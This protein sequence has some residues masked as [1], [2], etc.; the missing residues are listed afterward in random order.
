MPHRGWT[1]INVRDTNPDELP[2]DEAEYET[3]QACEKYPI[4]F[5]HTIV[6]DDWPDEVDVGRICVEHLTNDYVN[7]RR[8]EAEL[9]RRASARIRWLNRKWKTSAK[10]NKWL[11][12]DGHHMAVFPSQGRAGFGCILDG[13]FSQKSYPTERAAMLHIFDYLQRRKERLDV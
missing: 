2:M 5:V 11:K 9:K 13:R 12:T 3:C 6:H 7:P 1:C 10:G 8:H 4:R